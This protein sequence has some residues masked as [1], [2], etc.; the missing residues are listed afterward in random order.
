MPIRPT[1]PARNHVSFQE[2]RDATDDRFY[3]ASVRL[4][5]AYYGDHIDHLTE[6]EI[7][8]LTA[9]YG[10]WKKG[11]RIQNGWVHGVDARFMTNQR[12]RQYG[13]NPQGTPRTRTRADENDPWGTWTALPSLTPQKLFERLQGNLW[14]RHERALITYND[15]L[16][17]PQRDPALSAWADREDENAVA[18]RDLFDSQLADDIADSIDADP[19]TEDE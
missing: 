9:Q 2:A 11:K 6:Q 17:L 7:I 10:T 4:D 1:P 15:S 13:L 19:L 5:A 16:P 8:D 12:R 3:R 18:M 14:R